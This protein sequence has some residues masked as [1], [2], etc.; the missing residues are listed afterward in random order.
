MLWGNS[1]TSTSPAR[2]VWVCPVQQHASEG[3]ER[4]NSDEG[5]HGWSPIET[6]EIGFR[7]TSTYGPSPKSSVNLFT[8]IKL[9]DGLAIL[10]FALWQFSAIDFHAP[11]TL[12]GAVVIGVMIVLAVQLSDKKINAGCWRRRRA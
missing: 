8:V 11:L 4:Q 7:T 6:D 10:A 5:L 9:R 12:G 2:V 3:G 1:P